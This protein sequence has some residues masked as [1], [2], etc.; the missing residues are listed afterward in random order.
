MQTKTCEQNGLILALLII[1]KNVKRGAEWMYNSY[2]TFY[3]SKLFYKEFVMTWESASDC[4]RLDKKCK[5]AV[6]IAEVCKEKH[7]YAH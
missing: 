4:C 3:N 7:I 2:C 1:A 5:K 6:F